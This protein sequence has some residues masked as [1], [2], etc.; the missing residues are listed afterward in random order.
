MSLPLSRIS[1]TH[2]PFDPGQFFLLLLSDQGLLFSLAWSSLDLAA[3]LS[4]ISRA[5]VV[6]MVLFC[7]IGRVHID[8][9]DFVTCH[10]QWFL[11]E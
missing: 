10:A 8:L 2:Q 7:L 1:E 3:T 6:A 5:I 9:I 4:L 11:A